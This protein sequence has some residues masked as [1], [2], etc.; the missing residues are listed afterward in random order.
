MKI[1]AF[2]TP[3]YILH[4]NNNDEIKS[5]VEKY[6]Q[7]NKIEFEK[8]K[9]SMLSIAKRT[10]KPELLN[11]LDDLIVFRELSQND[12][13]VII[14]IELSNVQNRILGRNIDLKINKS[15]KEFLLKEGYDKAYGARQLRRT[16][17]KYLEDPLAEEILKGK[18]KNNSSVSVTGTKD[19]LN[20]K[21]SSS[22]TQKKS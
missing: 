7:D 14:N 6:Y 2:P 17:E 1:E 4:N 21:L 16:V 9:E 19:K 5:I 15:A 13:E 10:F 12:L 8:Y 18:I 11:R 20:F 22:K 3:I